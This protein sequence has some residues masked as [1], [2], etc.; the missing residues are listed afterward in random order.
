MGNRLSRHMPIPLRRPTQADVLSALRELGVPING[1][2]DVGVNSQT[3]SLKDAFPDLKHYLFEP[4]KSYWPL[5]KENY[6][7]FDYNLYPVALSNADGTA[8]LASINIYD[9]KLNA[10]GA[11]SH[12]YVSEKIVT[13]EEEPHLID[14]KEIKRMKLDTVMKDVGSSKGPF[15]LKIDVDGHE[16]PI[17]EGATETLK[18]CSVVIIEATLQNLAERLEFLLGHGFRLFDLVDVSYYA[19]VLWQVDLVLVSSS[20][21]EANPKLRPSVFE[22]P[23]KHEL[24]HL[25]GAEQVSNSSAAPVNDG[26]V[27][28]YAA[29]VEKS[30]QLKEKLLSLLPQELRPAC[31][32]AADDMEKEACRVANENIR[33]QMDIETIKKETEVLKKGCNVKHA[34][35]GSDLSFG[36]KHWEESVMHLLAN[37]IRKHAHHSWGELGGGTPSAYKPQAYR[38]PKLKHFPSFA[39]VTP[40]LNQGQFIEATI[41]SIVTQDYPNLHYHVQDGAS[42]DN[43]MQI[44]KQYAKKYDF[45]FESKPDRCHSEAINRGFEKVSGDIMAFVNSD[46]LLCPNALYIVADYFNRHPEVD[47]VYGHRYIINESGEETS[48]WY[49]PRYDKD[50]LRYICPIPQEATFWRRSAWDKSGGYIDE[51]LLFALDWD[52]WLRFRSSGA[53]F[54]R[55]PC[56]LGSFR[57]QKAQKSANT[58]FTIGQKDTALLYNREFRGRKP[59]AE[60]VRFFFDY[61]I[62]RSFLHR[63]FGPIF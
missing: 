46:D 53:R 17:L 28:T 55:V 59:R 52:L 54:A 44:V 37:L 56:F 12:S 58:M 45:T 2:L 24:W 51:S 22:K 26:S 20:V 25:H 29:V 47:V 11:A 5:I 43:T 27:E 7:K 57:I 16:L 61:V 49:M 48:R 21:V 63:K 15:L 31:T 42:S 23:F 9:Q 4:V 30:R 6:G 1:I 39:I 33:L 60:R 18:E 19:G 3:Q 10:G 41:K 50:E 36:L 38:R 62:V 40:S 13:Q 14:C 35:T 32:Q 8:Y 34:K